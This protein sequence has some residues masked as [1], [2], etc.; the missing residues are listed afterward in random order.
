MASFLHPGV[1]V[2]EA[3]NPPRAIEAASTSTAIFSVTERGPLSPTKVTSRTDYTRAFRRISHPGHHRPSQRADP[4]LRDG[5]VLRQ[6]RHHL[7][8]AARH[9]RWPGRRR[10]PVRLQR[11]ADGQDQRDVARRRGRT[12]TP[13][14]ASRRS[15][16]PSS[17]GSPSRFRIVVVYTPLDTGVQTIVEDWD[18]L[19][20]NPN[21]E[22]YVVDVLA[23]QPLHHLGSGRRQPGRPRRAP[24]LDRP[25]RPRAS[26]PHARPRPAA[27]RPHRRPRRRHAPPRSPDFTFSMLDDISDASLLVL[28]RVDDDS[29]QATLNANGIAY[30]LTRPHLDLFYIGS[31][32]KH[33]D[34]VLAT[35]AAQ[36]AVVEFQASGL[37]KSD[38]A[39]VY[40]PWIQVSNPVGVGKG[41]TCGSPRRRRWPASTPAPSEPRRVEGPGRG[42]GE[43]ARRAHLS[44]TSRTSSRTSSTRSASTPSATSRR[45][46]GAGA[47]APWCPAASGGTSRS[48]HGDLPPS[49]DLQR[50]PVGRLRGQRR[51][52]VGVAPPDHR[53]LHGQPLRQGAFAGSTPSEAY[54]VKCDGETTTPIDQVSG[55]GQRPR[56]LRAPPAGR[57]RGRQAEPDRQGWRVASPASPRSLLHLQ[58]DGPRRR[59]SASVKSRY[60]PW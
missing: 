20:I 12:A 30:C 15:S 9:E 45:R 24:D 54:F 7:L 52:A 37:P 5:R 41:P 23:P 13:R 43:P 22:N 49:D 6:R 1:Y 44:S 10:R 55:V 18:R 27:L 50:H 33:D 34:K 51:A 25:A 2:I 21:D 56:W 46:H 16:S 59:V 19:S 42:R 38:F 11:P 36:A 35:D 57:V 28:P 4:R 3:G 17:D 58:I 32:S 53:R 26:D 47:P 29:L 14:T 60:P 40:F 48:P 39:A 8:R 31:L